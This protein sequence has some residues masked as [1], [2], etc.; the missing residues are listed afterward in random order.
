MEL[1]M[2]FS[3]GMHL[4]RVITDYLEKFD[5]AHGL[6]DPASAERAKEKIRRRGEIGE[7]VGRLVD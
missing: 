4:G 7:I 3:V 6:L 2:G 5:V 1:W